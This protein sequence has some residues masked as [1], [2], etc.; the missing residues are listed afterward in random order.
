MAPE[1]ILCFVE[2]ELNVEHAVSTH[3][4]IYAF[5]CICLEVLTGQIPFPIKKNGQAVIIA[6]MRSDR[7][8]C[9]AQIP[10]GL[11]DAKILSLWNLMDKCR[12]QVPVLRPS[13]S[14]MTEV[15]GL[16]AVV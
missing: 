11:A 16:L 8:L 10:T 4:D 14:R 7:P 1:L 6:V 15:L 3:N 2:D 13:M 12:H 5:A 9:G